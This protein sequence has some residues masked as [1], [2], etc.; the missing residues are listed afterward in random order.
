MDKWI[1]VDDRLPEKDGYYLVFLQ[2]QYG[3]PFLLVSYYCWEDADYLIGVTDP[4]T[5]YTFTNA[6]DEETDVSKDVTHW[7]PLPK[8]PEA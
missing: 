2:P 4:Y 3:D 6:Y 7:M 8:P 5:I 1:S